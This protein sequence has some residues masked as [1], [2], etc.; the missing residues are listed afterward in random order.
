MN[1]EK[2]NI[3]VERV[4][5]HHLGAMTLLCNQRCDLFA[6]DLTIRAFG[7]HTANVRGMH[8]EVPLATSRTSQE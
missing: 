2:G 3:A 5:Y 1:T 8:H 7:W 6:A 4:S